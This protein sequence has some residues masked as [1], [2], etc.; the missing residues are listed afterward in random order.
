MHPLVIEKTTLVTVIRAENRITAG[1]TFARVP[2]V[3]GSTGVTFPLRHCLP[4]LD[5][6]A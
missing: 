5:P 1:P 3:D 4:L 6:F 2:T